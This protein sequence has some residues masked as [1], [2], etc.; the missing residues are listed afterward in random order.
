M[1]NI[2]FGL[3]GVSS[4]GEYYQAIL[5]VRQGR[6]RTGVIKLPFVS[7][8]MK[9]VQIRTMHAPDLDSFERFERRVKEIIAGNALQN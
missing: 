9:E 5:A 8:D 4:L 2:T 3:K 1:R 6:E 7:P